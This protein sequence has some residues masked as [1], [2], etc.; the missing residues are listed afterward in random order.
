MEREQL[1][2]KAVIGFTGVVQH[3]LLL[4]PDNTHLIYPLGSV[5]V[6]R[7]VVERSQTFLRGHDNHITSIICYKQSLSQNLEN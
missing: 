5:I 4:H 7:N 1:N 3:S 6:I 2:I